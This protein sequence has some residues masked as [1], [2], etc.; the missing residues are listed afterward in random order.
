MLTRWGFTSVFDT[1]SM[2]D[3]TRRIRDRIDSGEIAG[4]RIRS[5]GEI[6]IP[7]GAASPTLLYDVMG[8]MH[9]TLPEVATEAEGRETATRLL[10]AGTDGIKLYAQTFAPPILVLAPAAIRGA[11][12]EAH[13]RGKL[14]FAHP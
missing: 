3:N 9:I 12:D 1:G 13:R 7:P 5:T 2:W 11:V 8:T 14:V 4:P 10:D 6:L